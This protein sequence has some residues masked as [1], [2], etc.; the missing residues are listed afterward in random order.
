MSEN[1]SGP[2]LNF[3]QHLRSFIHLTTQA[4]LENVCKSALFLLTRVPS[5][6]HAVIEYIGTFYKVATFLHLRFNLNQKNPNY[7]DLLTDTNNITHINQ[8]IDHVEMSLIDLLEKSENKE[9]WSVELSQWL[10][11]LIGDISQNTGIT[12][13]ETQGLSPEEVA[14]FKMPSI[15]DGLE[16]WNNQCRPTQSILY[17]IQ[18]CFTLVTPPIQMTIIDLILNSSLKYGQRYDWILCYM[19]PFQTEIFIEKLLLAGLKEF[20]PQNQIKF[21]R[22]NAINFFCLNYSNL[23]TDM[24][25]KFLTNSSDEKKF[26]F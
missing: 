14:S 7:P 10:V 23:F 9:F 21:S 11:E 13:S 2:N 3:F 19:S 15:A 6:R 12:F 20:G 5:T 25:I 24:L 16:I 26:S 4:P 18:K 8:V 1:N 17:L 22:I